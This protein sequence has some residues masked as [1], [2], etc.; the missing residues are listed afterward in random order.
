MRVI[1]RC[2]NCEVINDIPTEYQF[3]FCR[4]CG[5]IV[6]YAPGEAI[7]SEENGNNIFFNSKQLS[8]S[9]AVDFFN[10]ADKAENSISKLVNEHEKKQT[11][12]LDLQAANMSDTIL[13][14][15]KQ[16]KTNELDEII[17]HCSNFNINI[18]ELEKIVIKLRKEGIIFLPKGWL[19]N[20]I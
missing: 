9:L 13:L 2:K 11:S 12:L 4:N 17:R 14:I 6:T 15:L 5:K 19:I 8:N 7:I 10:L 3:R 16:S 20:L 18:L 1:F